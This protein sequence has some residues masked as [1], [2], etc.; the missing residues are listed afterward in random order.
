MAWLVLFCIFQRMELWLKQWKIQPQISL[1]IRV[2]PVFR[3]QCNK[4]RKSIFKNNYIEEKVVSCLTLYQTVLC[5]QNEYTARSQS[6]AF[7]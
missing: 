4:R 1:H 7:V 5:T 3:L 2:D 6:R